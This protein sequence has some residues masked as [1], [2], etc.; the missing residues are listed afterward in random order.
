V[1]QFD[2][3]ES[4]LVEAIRVFEQN[5]PPQHPKL[6][7][8]LCNYA[9]LLNTTDRRD[10]AKQLIGRAKLQRPLATGFGESVVDLSDL[11]SPRK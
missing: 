7:W 2:K 9:F 6:T 10:E 11:T 4:L 1:K 3:A 5:L 8:T